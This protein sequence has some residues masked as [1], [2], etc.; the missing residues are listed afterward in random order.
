MSTT[1]VIGTAGHIDHGKSALVKALTGTDPDRLKEEQARG[2]TIDLGFAHTVIDDVN[3][4]F[5]D[6]P[7]HERFV[8]NMLAGAGGIDAVALVIAADESVMPQTR[9]H[10]EICRLL[11]VERG[12]I[13]LSKSD[14]VDADGLEIAALEARELVAGSF[15]EAA[16]ILAVSARTGAGLDE[17]RR[18][19]CDL[20]KGSTRLARAGVVRLPVD[21]VFTVK[22]F[23][24]V[25]TGTL[26]SGDIRAG[27]ELVVMPEGRPVRVRGVQVHGR[28][29]GSAHAPARA[30][31]NL[32][33]IEV[34]E[35]AR[36][37]TLSSADALTV[38]R[39][40]DARVELIAKGH[41]LRALRHGA[42]VRVH[43]GT[44]ERLGRVAMCAVKSAGESDWRLAAVG[45]SSVEAAPGSEVYA[46]LRLEQPMAL[47]R[48]D[49][50]IL[51]ADSPPM[52][53]G[54]GVVIDPAPPPAG[55]RRPPTLARFQAVDTSSFARTWLGEAGARGLG[56]VDLIARGGLEADQSRDL[57][58]ALVKHGDAVLVG[59]R[60][61]DAAV[62]RAMEARVIAELE[63]FHSREPKER[64]MPREALRER[65]APHAPASLVDAVFTRMSEGGTIAGADRVALTTHRAVSS[66]E[67]DQQAAR[68]AGVLRDAGL[69]PPDPAAIATE[70][71]LSADVVT[72]A[73]QN[74][75][76]ERTAV[77][78]DGL[79]FHAEALARLRQDVQAL[80]ASRATPGALA[81]VDVASFKDRYGLSRK[82]A[83]PLL[84]WLDRERVTK[85]V[86]DARVILG[87]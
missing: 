33:A 80:G 43:H 29:V 12:L 48:G 28:D 49:R 47:T 2:I 39:R 26:V 82:F 35:L 34:S 62:V 55:L 79:Y 19:L 86:G 50:F 23:G 24:T 32:G 42:R 65:A 72:R 9:E 84:E 77:R 1:L 71:G 30:A 36:G 5:V 41:G 31:I 46:R 54:G 18:A 56:A 85:R 61:V 53:I 10:F 37:V 81:R 4:A 66:P 16:P 13:V 38:T 8:R 59:P 51:R 52:T 3:V 11:G 44:A 22:G 15:L 70:T 21:R 68:V 78:L 58:S 87:G 64:G 73:L 7:G 25:V 60:V 63:A 45:E 69:M 27:D 20:A 75:A 40:V 14:R 83:I 57:M 76:R 6:V 17:L 67:E 74:L